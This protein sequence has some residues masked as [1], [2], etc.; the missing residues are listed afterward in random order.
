MVPLGMRV[1]AAVIPAAGVAVARE[2]YSTRVGL[3]AGRGDG[4][5]VVA[6]RVSSEHPQE[7]HD[8]VLLAVPRGSGGSFIDALATRLPSAQVRDVSIR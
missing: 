7:E 5:L 2:N 6:E 4:R 3:T 8:M 1:T